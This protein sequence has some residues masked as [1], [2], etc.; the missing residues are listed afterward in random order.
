MGNICH[1][2]EGSTCDSQA[3]LPDLFHALVREYVRGFQ[4]VSIVLLPRSYV[5]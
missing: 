2:F 5:A 4:Q 3:N 1:L